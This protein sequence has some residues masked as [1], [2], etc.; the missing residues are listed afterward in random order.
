MY[1]DALIP[2]RNRRVLGGIYSK[3]DSFLQSICLHVYVHR[4]THMSTAIYM[5]VCMYI[6]GKHMDFGY[7]AGGKGGEKCF[8]WYGVKVVGATG[9]KLPTA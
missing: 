7:V 4:Y 6:S 1:N 8:I 2:R 5:R 3:E 9:M